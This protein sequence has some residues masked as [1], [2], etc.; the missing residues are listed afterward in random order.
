MAYVPPALRKAKEVKEVVIETKELP[1]QTELEV[2]VRVEERM[3]EYR[4]TVART[5][6]EEDDYIRSQLKPERK[7]VVVQQKIERPVEK[8]EDE[9]VVV[10]RKIPKKKEFNFDEPVIHRNCEEDTYWSNEDDDT[11]WR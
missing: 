11:L 4:E 8:K 2:K 1:K 6:K 10:Q 7:P 3:R 5:R 9:W